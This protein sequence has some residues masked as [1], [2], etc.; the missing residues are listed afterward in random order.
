MPK[1]Q[2]DRRQAETGRCHEDTTGQT[3]QNKCASERANLLS[4]NRAA[5]AFNLD[6]YYG[7]VPREENDIQPSIRASS[8]D[9]G[10]YPRSP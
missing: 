8:S 4:L 6:T 1:Q 10:E 7:S 3:F 5:V 2:R 9:K